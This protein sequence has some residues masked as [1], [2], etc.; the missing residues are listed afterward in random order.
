MGRRRRRTS[1]PATPGT[2]T[3]ARNEHDGQVWFYDPRPR[4]HHAEDHLRREPRPGRRT[5]TTTGRTTSP[6][7]RTAASSWPR[8]ARACPHLVGVTEKRRRL[9]AGPQRDQRQRVHRP[10]VQPGRPRSCSRTSRRRATSSRSPARGTAGTA[11][12][13][14]ATLQ[15]A[16]PGSTPCWV[17]SVHPGEAARRAVRS[18]QRASMTPSRCASWMRSW[19]G[20][21]ALLRGV[22]RRMQLRRVNGELFSACAVVA[23]RATGRGQPVP[24]RRACLRRAHA[25]ESRFYSGCRDQPGL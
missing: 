15:I 14:P 20:E 12:D 8:T 11:T 21:A 5:P 17:R 10:D 16:G 22:S 13:G 23:R 25:G 18:R 9:S 24:V 19:R 2:T 4:D 3:A 7:R 6:S 1:S